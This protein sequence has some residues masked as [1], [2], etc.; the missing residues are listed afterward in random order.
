MGRARDKEDLSGV[1]NGRLFDLTR[2]L[3]TANR[4]VPAG[5]RLPGGQAEDLSAIIKGL[6]E[7]RGSLRSLAASMP[8]GVAG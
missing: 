3:R 2:T 5:G 6:L 8:T 1:G 4:R 7:R